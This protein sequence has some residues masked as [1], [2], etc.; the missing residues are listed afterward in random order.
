[1][2]TDIDKTKRERERERAEEL[3]RNMEKLTI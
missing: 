2:F 3:E 1:M